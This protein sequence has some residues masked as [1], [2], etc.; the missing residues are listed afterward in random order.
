M[1][2][3]DTDIF[4]CEYEHQGERCEDRGP[5]KASTNGSGKWLCWRHLNCKSQMEGFEIIRD[6]QRKTD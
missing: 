2:N 1:H 5:F 6:S 4:R 3:Y